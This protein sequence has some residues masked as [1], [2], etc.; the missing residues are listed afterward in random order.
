MLVRSGLILRAPDIS[1]AAVL[2]V[3]DAADFAD[4]VIDL[5]KKSCQA[6]N[7]AGVAKGET[8]VE[9]KKIADKP[10]RLVTIIR[11][12]GKDEKTSNNDL[13][14]FRVELDAKTLLIGGVNTPEQLEP[15]VKRFTPQPAQSLGKDTHVATTTKILPGKLQTSVYVNLHGLVNSFNLGANKMPACTP[16]A[17][18]QGTFA[19]GVEAQ[20]VVPFDALAAVFRMVQPNG[21]D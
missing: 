13:P 8:K 9:A 14:L 1:V 15:F 4:G 6:A 17:F 7:D 20:F 2:R 3:D 21:K 19:N 10:A 16:L 12:P 5:L 11:A 18:A